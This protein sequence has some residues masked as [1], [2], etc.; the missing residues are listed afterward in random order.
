[1][2]CRVHST[3]ACESNRINNGSQC[4]GQLGAITIY[5]WATHHT[6]TMRAHLRFDDCTIL[7]K[8]RKAPRASPQPWKVEVDLAFSQN[9]HANLLFTMRQHDID[10]FDL[11]RVH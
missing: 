7:N 2:L 5:A 4:Q 6:F 1:M 11:R 3:C 8:I 10:M 9:L